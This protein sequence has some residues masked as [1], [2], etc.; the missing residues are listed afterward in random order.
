LW[1]KIFYDKIKAEYSARHR[2]AENGKEE[3]DGQQ[4]TGS[5]R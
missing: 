2:T 5:A 3:A 4:G 1:N